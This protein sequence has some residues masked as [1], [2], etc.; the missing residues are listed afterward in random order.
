VE[1][2]TAPKDACV[3]RCVGVRTLDLLQV[4]DILDLGIGAEPVV[5][6]TEV[7]LTVAEEDRLITRMSESRDGEVP[8]LR[9]ESCGEKGNGC[10]GDVPE[11][12]PPFG[13]PADRAP[14]GEGQPAQRVGLGVALGRTVAVGVMGGAVAVGSW[15][16]L[17]FLMSVTMS[18]S[19]RRFSMKST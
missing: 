16:D 3:R 9:K 19:S 6:A 1:L 7:R 15:P 8:P 4:V 11:E 5:V 14:V 12:A 17:N 18:P 10:E 2:P 13:A